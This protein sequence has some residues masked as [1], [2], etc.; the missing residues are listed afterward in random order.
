MPMN[1]LQIDAARTLPLGFQFSQTK[2]QDFEDCARRFYL[3][4][5]LCQP[6][7]SPLAQPQEEF[8][9]AIKR[10]QRFHRIVERH[11]LGISLE[12]LRRSTADDPEI[13]NWLNSYQSLLGRFGKFERV[14]PEVTL[15][16]K[17]AGYPLVA[18]FDLIGLQGPNVVAVDW[19]TGHLPD[20]SRLSSRMQTVIYLYMLHKEVRQL[21]GPAVER[22]TLTYAGILDNDLR[23]FT[24][25]AEN[26]AIYEQHIRSIIE[27]IEE[28]IH[29]AQF[30]KVESNRPCRF[31]YYRGLCERGT[32][33][34]ATLDELEIEE[35]GSLDLVD[36]D[37]DKTSVE[38]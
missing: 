12:I 15:S 3:K 14:W 30:A 11:Q 29:R 32:S 24:V 25:D 37:A 22:F 21:V 17:I 18:K 6:W 34:Y 28:S 36:W 26:V 2:L 35:D 33:P 9:R 4:Y 31:C 19:K 7:P 8:E 13:Q 1:A 20:S 5:I 38:F 27:A 10:G 16:T 23:S